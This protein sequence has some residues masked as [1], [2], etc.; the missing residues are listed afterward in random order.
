LRPYTRTSFHHQPE[1]QH[2]NSSAIHKNVGRL[3][4]LRAK[5]GLM[6]RNKP[7]FYS[8]T[9]LA[10]SGNPGAMFNPITL[11]A[12]RLITNSYLAGV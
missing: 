7:A 10:R 3:P 1:A 6:H 5:S 8:I 12:L 2:L 9:S 4:H 11:A